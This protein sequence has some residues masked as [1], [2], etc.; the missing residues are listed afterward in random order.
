MSGPRRRRDLASRLA[1]DLER[2]DGRILVK[3]AS[4]KCGSVE[5][6]NEALRFP[7][8]EQHIEGEGRVPFG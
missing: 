8:R 2:S 7:C 1:D 6:R 3:S 5:P 4:Y